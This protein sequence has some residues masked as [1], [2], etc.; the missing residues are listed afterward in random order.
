MKQRTE[1]ERAE[2]LALFAQKNKLAA[3]KLRLEMER[4][5]VVHTAPKI[6]AG[7]CSGPDEPIPSTVDRMIHASVLAAKKLY[8]KVNDA[9]LEQIEYVNKERASLNA[10]IVELDP[11]PGDEEP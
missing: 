8:H 3:R 9:Y 6:L 11:P 5:Y 2:L 7:M 4:D 10:R 1:E